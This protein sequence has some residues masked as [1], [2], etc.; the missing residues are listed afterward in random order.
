[1][2]L[3]KKEIYKKSLQ[4]AERRNHKY[5]YKIGDRYIYPE[6]VPK[7]TTEIQQHHA[8][9]LSDRRQA[10]KDRKYAKE[11]KGIDNRIDNQFGI[12][13]AARSIRNTQ[14]MTKS[15]QGTTEY[16]G[17]DSYLT[18]LTDS[19]KAKDQI[20]KRKL[21]KAIDNTDSQRKSAH[22]GYEADKKVFPEGGSTE[23]LESQKKKTSMRKQ[24]GASRAAENERK[25]SG[26]VEEGST[27]ELER[28]K[29]KTK[30]RKSKVRTEAGVEAGRDRVKKKKKKPTVK[31]SKKVTTW[32]NAKIKK[33]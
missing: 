23:E 24:L 3:Y 29:I 21:A 13:G 12:S 30:A 27:E 1:M 7:G 9:V 11:S 14:Q 17:L 26:F 20:K 33:W 25:K 4:H 2:N 15:H 8:Q 28:Q 18:R 32:D 22:A 16:G 19:D 10:K 31:G 5:L 6:D